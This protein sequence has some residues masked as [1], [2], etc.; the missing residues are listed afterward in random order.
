MAPNSWPAAEP[1]EVSLTRGNA[2][3]AIGL[4][5]GGLRGL[6]V[7]DWDVLDGYPAGTVPQGRRGGVLLPWPNRL[8]NG[9]WAWAGEELQL[10]VSSPESPN[11]MHGFVSW[12]LWT[13]LAATDSTASVGSII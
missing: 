12:Q 5:G 3:L 1:G 11:A 8:R 2:R 6:E 9:R 13:V 10:P 7:G 4:R